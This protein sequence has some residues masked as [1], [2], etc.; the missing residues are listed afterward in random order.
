M[1]FIKN[2]TALLIIDM[3]VGCFAVETPR[4][5]AEGV[6]YRINDLARVIR[7]NKG[8]V[9]LIQHE[10]PEG[11]PFARGSSEWQLL[12][13]LDR[14][15]GDIIINKTAC[16]SFYRTT[17]KSVL[18]REKINKVIITGCATDYC[19]DSTVRAAVSHDF[20]VVVAADGHTTADKAHADAETV[21]THHNSIWQNLI[22]PEIKVEVIN[23]KDLI[24]QLENKN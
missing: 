1:D 24:L 5:D 20:R 9:I 12:P 21:I 19:V 14:Q 16:D 18:D 11:E 23:T 6:V 2:T 13:T 4:Y 15:P 22:H 7:K 3:Q 10:S 17:L 8:I